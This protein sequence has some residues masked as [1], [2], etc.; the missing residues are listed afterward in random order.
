MPEGDITQRSG[1]ITTTATATTINTTA[2]C[3]RVAVAR[4]VLEEHVRPHGFVVEVELCSHLYTV[5]RVSLFS[6]TGEVREGGPRLWMT[7]EG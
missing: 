7:R 4:E 6:R 5:A 3:K 1:P 2:T